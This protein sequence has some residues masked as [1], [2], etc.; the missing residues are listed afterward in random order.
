MP[1]E[2]VFLLSNNRKV[3][4][5]RNPFRQKVQSSVGF[6]W[7]S[8]HSLLALELSGRKNKDATYL[9]MYVHP[10]SGHTF[11]YYVRTYIYLFVCTGFRW[12]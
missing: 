10:R 12:F 9:S 2:N 11:G 6:R 3:S 8:T 7:I 5:E 1:V 4:P